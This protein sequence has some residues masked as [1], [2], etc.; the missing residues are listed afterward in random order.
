[1]FAARPSRLPQDP[2]YVADFKE[3]GYFVNNDGLIRKI[4]YPDDTFQFFITNNERYN[5]VHREAFHSE[6]LSF[7]VVGPISMGLYYNDPYQ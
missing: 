5:E 7:S 2:T 6:F 1:M 4:E 3:L